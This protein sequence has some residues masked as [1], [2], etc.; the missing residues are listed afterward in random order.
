VTTGGIYWVRATLNGCSTID[1]VAIVVGGATSFSLG[2]DTSG[3]VNQSISLGQNQTFSKY[4]WSTGSTAPRITVNNSGIFWLE[5]S[6]NFGCRYRDTIRVTLL[7][8]PIINLGNDTMM[9]R[10]K[11]P[12]VLGQTIS[13]ATYLWQDGSTNAFYPA[14][15]PGV[16]WVQAT[17]NGCSARDSV[18]ITVSDPSAFS[19]GNDRVVCNGQPL[20]LGVTGLYTKY[21][22]STGSTSSTI[23]VS[24]TGVFWLEAADNTGCSYRDSISVAFRSPPAFSLGPDT[25]I[26]NNPAYLLDVSNTGDNYSWQDNATQPQYRVNRTGSYYVSVTRGGCTATDTVAIV[27]KTSPAPDLGPDGSICPGEELII[28]HSV[29]G[30]RS[31]WQ[32][33][34]TDPAFKVT[35]PGRYSVKVENECG[36]GSDEVIIAVGSCNLLIPNAFTPGKS[37]NNIF[38]LVNAF[39]LK[40]Y[41]LQ[42]FNRWGQQVYHSTRSEEGWNGRYNGLE[43]PQGSYVYII[44]YTDPGAGKV[45]KKGTVTLIR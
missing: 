14:A 5:A 11:F 29:T 6:N 25:I 15:Q 41:S 4:L 2:S 26:C 18:T 22:W 1:T 16:Y 34:T 42:V 45:L 28:R 8:V 13:G 36:T 40:D 9:C 33:G 30:V 17:L 23:T 7:S 31:T 12:L 10:G 24:N 27:F 3:C 20:V 37:V 19:L 38:R 35:S 21:L 32:D 44:S 43:Q 39:G